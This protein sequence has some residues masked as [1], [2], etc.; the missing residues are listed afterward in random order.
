[1]RSSRLSNST[2]SN[3]SN[4]TASNLSNSTTGNSSNDSTNITVNNTNNITANDANNITVNN[5]NNI[6]NNNRHIRFKSPK[7]SNKV[8]RRIGTTKIIKSTRDK[9]RI[10]KCCIC[11]EYLVNHEKYY[12]PCCHFY[13]KECIDPW[14]NTKIICPECRIPIYI[15]DHD[16]F[17]AYNKFLIEQRSNPELVRDNISINDNNISLMF[18]KH[19]Y[20]Y[21]VD[22]LEFIQSD[23][24]RDMANKEEDLSE[25]YADLIAEYDDSDDYN[26]AINPN[27]RYYH[28]D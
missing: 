25:R 10:S 20:N 1:M 22:D 7:K 26:D 16:E 23:K 3:L 12:L 15:H 11:L 24:V 21:D 18:I 9:I 28:S 17:I 27:F 14:I 8:K 13:H 6:T 2:A 4:S 19:T 5:T